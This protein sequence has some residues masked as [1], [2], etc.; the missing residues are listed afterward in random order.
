[1]KPIL[2]AC[3][4]LEDEIQH[5][6]GEEH[7]TYPVV[8]MERGL[9]E[10][11][12]KLHTHLQEEIILLER[13]YDTILLGYCRCGNV[14]RGLMSPCA[15]LAAIDCDDCVHMLLGKGQCGCRSLYFTGGWLRSERFIGKEYRAAQE[16]YG[17]CKAERIYQRLLSGY[18]HLRMI[19]TGAYDLSR[20]QKDAID[21]AKCLNLQ[22]EVQQGELSLLREFLTFQW[23]RHVAASKPGCPLL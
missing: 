15:A 5:I 21:T 14:W 22:F 13:D 7:L 23:N 1:M 18:T 12:E 16:K 3:S 11:P 4:M 2:I 19:D 9:H 8:W 17:V 20:Y 6:M 10:F